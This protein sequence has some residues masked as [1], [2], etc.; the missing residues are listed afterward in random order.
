MVPR[1]SLRHPLLVA[2]VVLAVTIWL[3]AIQRVVDTERLAA[4]TVVREARE[5][6]L[7]LA[8][9]RLNTARANGTLTPSA[10]REKSSYRNS[11][12]ISP[13]ALKGLPADHFLELAAAHHIVKNGRDQIASIGLTVLSTDPE[14][15]DLKAFLL[16]RAAQPEFHLRPSH[17]LF[18]LKKLGSNDHK[19]L[20]QLEILSDPDTSH[21]EVI[22]TDDRDL[23]FTA[24]NL[25][26]QADPAGTVIVSEEPLA[27]SVKLPGFHTLNNISLKSTIVAGPNLFLTPRLLI[28]LSGVA[29][30]GISI[31][32]IISSLKERKLANLKTEL[33]AAMAH[34]LRTPLAGQSLVLESLLGAEPVSEAKRNEYL[35]LPFAENQRLSHLAEQFLT[36][37][38]LDRGKSLQLQ[39]HEVNPAELVTDL[40]SLLP[41]KWKSAN[42]PKLNISPNLPLVSIDQSLLTTAL[43]NLLDNAW[44]YSHEIKDITLSVVAT[45]HSLQFFVE[46]KGVGI[47]SSDQ[48]CIFQR[49]FRVDQLLTRRRDG[50]GLGLSIVQSVAQAHGGSVCVQ[51]EVGGGST[52]TLELPVS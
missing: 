6:A 18:L 3:I 15:A 14:N 7:K 22:E 42:L 41:E 43:L 32:A 30:L 37:S 36:F 5:L 38:R 45:H 2:G 27:H 16:D 11:Q 9:D 44:K 12:T 20:R 28:S 48:K 52:F 25:S 1:P 33:A 21:Y 40:V 34:E 13:E 51:S 47:S 17:Q 46:D 35:K 8:A 23:I 50:I 31:Y 26:S 4:E 10:I 39:K 29:L 19:L 24:A 49:F